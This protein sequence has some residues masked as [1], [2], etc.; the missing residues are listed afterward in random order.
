MADLEESQFEI[1]NVV[2]GRG[3]PIEVSDFV[4]GGPEIET[5]DVDLPGED[6]TVFGYDTHGGSTLVWEMASA[7]TYT[8]AE[9][10]AALQRLAAVWGNRAVRASP[11]A[12]VP[13]RLRV[14]GGE[15]VV[16]YG[17]PRRLEA[18][19]TRLIRAGFV[20]YA[21]DFR[22]ADSTFYDDVEEQV[23][24]DLLP[25]IG[26]GLILPFT[27]PAVLAPLG[28]SDSSRLTNSGDEATW[29]VITFSGPITNPGVEWLATGQTIQLITTLAYDQTATI[30]TRPWARTVLRSDGASL[31]GTIRGLRLAEMAIPPGSTEVKFRGQ[32]MTGTARCAIRWRSARSTP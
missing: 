5:G 19:A 1:G 13:L 20:E 21:A 8:A 14:P 25:Q 4:W 7:G 11:R 15:T 16:V 22:T 10:R 24:L 30:D 31:A 29:P 2:F 23:L 27:L 6:G 28:D 32:D 26:E 3:C 17:R 9:C 18:G 12:V